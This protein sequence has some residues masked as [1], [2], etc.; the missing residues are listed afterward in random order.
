[1]IIDYKDLIK[2]LQIIPKNCSKAYVTIVND[3]ETGVSYLNF[4]ILRDNSN[5][6]Y[7]I[8]ITELE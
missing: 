6:S 3:N 1:M 4:E 2:K 7:F 8:N 5:L